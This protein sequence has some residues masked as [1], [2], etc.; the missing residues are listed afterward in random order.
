MPTQTLTFARPSGA[1]RVTEP[2]PYRF[3]HD[4]GRTVFRSDA[5]HDFSTDLFTVMGKT[6]SAEARK[7]AQDRIGGLVRAAFADVERA[8]VAGINPNVHRPDLWQPQ[9]DYP[10]PLWDL[11]SAGDTDGRKFDVPKFTSSSALT[12]IAT[13][14]TEPAG[15]SLVTELQTVTP[16]QIWGKVEIT[17]QAWRQ[18]GN[19]QLSTILWNQM[20]REYFEDREAAVAA[21]LATLTAA[22]DITLT[23]TPASTP[24]NDDDR[25]TMTDLEL[26]LADLQFVRGGN[27]MRAFAAHQA[28]YRVAARVKDST[29]R[30]LYPQINPENANGVAEGQY[31]TISVGGVTMI[32]AYALGTPGTAATN[33]WLFDPAIVRGWASAPERLQW[34]FGATVQTANTPQLSFVTVGIYSDVAFANLDISGVRQVIFDPSV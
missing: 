2:L 1:T 24:D 6:S 23:G 12:G 10:T 17:R 22:A 9:R 30:A 5:A 25:A 19:P 29:G 28:L 14:K 27:R 33:S 4:G 11:V 20:L 31:S 34:N 16:D 7:A 8:D 26:A 18:G 15:G 32:P 21:F 3:S 13:E